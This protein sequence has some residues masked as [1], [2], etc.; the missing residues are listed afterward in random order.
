MNFHLDDS[1]SPRRPSRLTPNEERKSSS[2]AHQWFPARFLGN[3]TFGTFVA[4]E[5]M[6]FPLL[7]AFTVVAGG[8][9]VKTSMEMSM[10][11]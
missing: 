4:M 5:K 11:M 8:G 2:R 10:D 6:R 7:V 1:I 3:R 9:N